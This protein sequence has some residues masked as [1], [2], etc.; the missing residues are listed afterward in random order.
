MDAVGAGG[1]AR[2]EDYD[3]EDL[4]GPGGG[5]LGGEVREGGEDVGPIEGG[6]CWGGEG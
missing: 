6:C 5:V 1:D 3:V 2:A 4:G